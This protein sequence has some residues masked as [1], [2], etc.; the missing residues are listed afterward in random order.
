MPRRTL[1]LKYA[2]F[3]RAGE[4]AREFECRSVLNQET[5]LSL[6]FATIEAR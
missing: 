3:D 1:G 4:P 5:P 6:V 2:P